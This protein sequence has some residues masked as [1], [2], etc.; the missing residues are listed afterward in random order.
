MCV[1]ADKSSRATPRPLK[2]DHESSPA[3]PGEPLA[4]WRFFWLF[5]LFWNFSLDFQ[6][7][8]AHNAN[9]A[10]DVTDTNWHNLQKDSCF[11]MRVEMNDFCIALY[12]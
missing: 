11:K 7:T 4:H 3:L 9:I 5:G 10:K 8:L 2:N 1:K 12:M 6:T